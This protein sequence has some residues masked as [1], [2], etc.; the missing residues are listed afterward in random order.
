MTRLAT[1]Y[2]L[3][4]AAYLPAAA[5]FGSPAPASAQSACSAS[6]LGAVTCAD[7]LLT[8][9]VTGTVTTGTT[10]LSGPGLVG[11]SPT[12]I[13]ANLTGDI[14]TTGNNQPALMLT[15]P[16][17]LT[18]T[19]PGTLTTTGANSDAAL[20]T[21][22]TV[23]A[24]LGTLNTSGVLSRGANV[25][26][27]SGPL[28]LSLNSVTTTGDGSTAALLRSTGNVNFNSTNLLSTTGVGAPAIDIA[29]NPVVC[30]TFAG[31]CS[32]T[33][34][35]NQVGTTGLNS[36]GVLITAQGPTSVTIGTLTTAGAT[37]PGLNL[38]TD[39]TAC[40]II[41]A[42]NCGTA[43][44]VGTLRTLGIGSIGAL[45]TAAGP[46][47]ATVGTLS[48]AGANALGLSL[49]TDPTAC[50]IVGA[51]ACGTN[52]TVGSLTTQGAGA[53]GILVRAA[54][55]TTGH[56]GLVQTAGLGANAIDIATTP[57]V[58]LVLGI[59]GCNVTLT[60]ATGTPGNVTTTG[61]NSIGVL[62]NSPGNITT[63]L[64]AISTM[65]NNSPGVSLITNPAACLVL[66]AGACTINDTTGPVTTGGSNS[67]GTIIRGAGDP[68]TVVTGPTTT[69]GPGSNGVD[70]AG[71]GTISV[72]TGPVI[73]SG[74]G[75][76]GIV[77]AGGALP[78]VVICAS[79]ATSGSAAPGVLVNATGQINLNCG[80]VSTTGGPNSGGVIVNGGTGPV[81]VTV[82]PVTT[83][84][85][86][87]AGITVGTTTGSQTIV[88]GGVNVTGPGS[89]GIVAVGSGCSDINITANGPVTSASGDAIFANTQCAVRVT[90]NAGATVTG[91]TSGINVTSGTTA[92]ILLNAGV[93]AT[94]GPAIIAT[95]GPATIT[96]TA[97]GSITGRVVLTG[98]NDVINNGG[99][100]T[101]I[102]TSDFGGGTDVFNNLAGGV[103]RTS[104]TTGVLANCETF[105]NAGAISMV[106]GVATDTLSLC[107]NYVGSGAASLGVDVGTSAGGLIADRLI[108]G[109]NA[110]G[111][112]VI[113][114]TLLNPLIIDPDG[115]LVV[116][117]ASATGTPFTLGGQTTFGLINLSLAQSG[118]NTF[119]VTRPTLGAIEPVVVGDLAQNL[120]Y[121]S[122]DIYSN[123]AALRRSDFGANRRAGLGVWGQAYYSEDRTKGQSYSVF[124]T[125]FNVDRFKTKRQGIQGGIDYLI[126][127]NLVVGFTGG[128]ERATADIRGS[129]SRFRATGYNFGGYAIF[130]G[131]TGFFGDLLVKYDRSK[132]KF[133]NV[134][135]ATATGSPHLKSRGAQGELGY[136]FGSEAMRFDVDAGLA[137][138]RS[139]IDSYSVGTIAFDYDRVKSTRGHIG[140]RATFGSGAIAPFVDAKLYHEFKGDTNL[141]LASG[142]AFDTI[143]SRGRGTWG[144][145]EA[146]IG[147]Q[148][149]SGPILA[150]WADVGDVKGFGV[151]AGFRFGGGREAILLPP[152]PMVR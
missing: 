49:T 79:V 150:A 103:V 60:P 109:G 55:P 72:T 128:Y 91:G 139:S 138:V 5:L 19:D 44:N 93:S 117:A 40:V 25:T 95:G 129:A 43:F 119:L 58:C 36:P 28:G 23:A 83:T 10:V 141:R 107:G 102:G 39:P 21:G 130:G 101:A 1:R 132:L 15:T 18:I 8:T 66:G 90:T 104:G 86:T 26:S 41:G 88:T 27:T 135:F 38:T 24:T 98:S 120:W 71:A 50:V 75:S 143:D 124:G 113:N 37:S 12:A 45:V 144:R 69:T 85:G 4:S 99:I 34:V 67:P 32:I 126:G 100:F 16:G 133:G 47:S 70:V 122:A 54:G 17:L 3:V 7:P 108:I 148:N 110:S 61:A 115:V 11:S 35:A 57:A 137:Y 118:G 92:T 94:N 56:V 80:P 147:S 65:G 121:Q 127:G 62:V 78:V 142:S 152:A 52:F 13:V 64:G 22:G 116:S 145:I 123:Y 149:S 42:G 73:T 59:G 136:R 106:N 30:V 84:G 31:G 9:P 140:A 97:T 53:T 33:A 112:T 20:L 63:N 81:A 146:G 151:K 48:T 14:T 105:N 87:S 114:P 111:S 131:E 68:I 96:T 125:G 29:T 2:L 46:T 134:L 89:G 76:T 51:G 77:V 74:A 6:L 82:G